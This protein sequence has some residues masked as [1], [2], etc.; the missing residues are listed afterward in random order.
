MGYAVANAGHVKPEPQDDRQ[1]SYFRRRIPED[2]RLDPSQSI[3]AQFDLLRV[4]DPDRFPAFFDFR[5]H[6]YFVR[7]SKRSEVPD[8]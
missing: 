7:I 4:A 8:A 2:S 6:R 3:A 1:P 5:G